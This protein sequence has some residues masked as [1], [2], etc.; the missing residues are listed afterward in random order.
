MILIGL[1]RAMFDNI[2]QYMENEFILG[3]KV[4]IMT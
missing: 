1:L 4:P 3:T 2:W